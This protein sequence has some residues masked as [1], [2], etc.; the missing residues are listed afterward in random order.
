MLTSKEANQDGWSP[1]GP[2]TLYVNSKIAASWLSLETYRALWRWTQ[3]RSALE[4]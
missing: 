4:L 3:D 1:Y 2:R